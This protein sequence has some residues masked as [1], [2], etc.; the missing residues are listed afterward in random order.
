MALDTCMLNKFIVVVFTGYYL[1]SW[2]R[3]D[4]MGGA[5]VEHGETGNTGIKRK[6]ERGNLE[7]MCTIKCVLDF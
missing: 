4:E 6:E 5:Y 2:N 3:E 1:F 7:W